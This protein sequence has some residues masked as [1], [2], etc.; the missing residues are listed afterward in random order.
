MSGQ[1]AALL[2]IL[3][4]I[5]TEIGVQWDKF[6]LKRE[7]APYAVVGLSLLLAVVFVWSQGTLALNGATVDAVFGYTTVTVGL[8]AVI[9]EYVWK[10]FLLKVWNWL[11]E[12]S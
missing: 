12:L 7:N 1:I 2:A 9:Y 8:A 6:P 11:R 3:V 5:I 10:A 4:P